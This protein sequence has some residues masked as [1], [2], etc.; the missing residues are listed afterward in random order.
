MIPAAE[1]E[2]RARSILADAWIM[3]ERLE[4]TLPPSGLEVEPGDA[5]ILN[6]LGADRHY[7]VTEINDGADRAMELVRVSP[8]V[9]EAP[10]GAAI[11]TPPPPVSV[12][13]APVWEVMDLPLFRDDADPA[14]PWLAAFADPWPG[15]VAFYRASGESAPAL[16]GT[17]PIPAVMGRLNAALGAGVSGRW[18]RRSIDVAL[19]FGAL[20]SRE[21]ED[22]LSGA[23]AV[24][25]ESAAGGWE[26]CQFQNADL[27][28]NGDWRLSNLLRGQAGTETQAEAG[29]AVGARFVLLTPAVTQAAFSAAHRGLAFEWS[30]GPDGDIPGTE[31]FTERQLTMTARGLKPFSPVNLRAAKEGGDIRLSWIR[32]TRLGGDSWEGEVPLSE[33]SERYVV[34]IFDGANE[35]RN[36][37]TQTPDYL[38]TAADIAADFG[39]GGPGA[40]L[41]FSIAQLSDAVGEGAERKGS[42]NVV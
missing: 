2:A 7:R 6:D 34:R 9:Y 40:S 25:I 19:S 42:V 32:R 35:V 27:L 5:I 17:A 33:T 31:N 39:P 29:A 22:I 14:A 1:A 10:V 23:N 16:T 11:F 37:E 18:D 24:A 4:F 26:I 8:G 15:G 3:R 21:E 20:S 28:A 41:T 12:F 38:Y 36:I 30:A 13:S